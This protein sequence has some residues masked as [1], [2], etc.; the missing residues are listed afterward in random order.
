[1]PEIQDTID[2]TPFTWE[3]D[4]IYCRCDTIFRSH[5]KVHLV[6][7]HLQLVSKDPCPNCGSHTSAHRM[8][9]APH[10]QT[11]GG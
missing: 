3:P 9:G 8:S 2:W 4:E 6:E 5:G 1:M 11:L 10:T 7:G